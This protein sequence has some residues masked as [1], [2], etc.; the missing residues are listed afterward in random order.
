LEEGIRLHNGD[1]LTI[2]SEGFSVNG[3][4]GNLVKI[5]KTI[6]NHLSSITITPLYRNLDVEFSRSLHAERRIPVDILLRETED[7]F[8][9]SYRSPF[10]S[11]LSTFNYPHEPA[12]NA[13]KALETIR[14]QLAKLGDTPYIARE[15]RIE[16]AP[17]FIPIS[18]LNEWRRHTII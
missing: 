2:G 11:H 6:T 5:N 10:N 16:S 9:L 12:R 3:V 1:G 8:E 13:D 17:Y 15:I 7:G 18:T 14:T 4:D